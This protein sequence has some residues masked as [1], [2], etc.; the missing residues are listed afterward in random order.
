MPPRFWIAALL[1]I[2]LA[3]TFLGCSDESSN[4]PS[5][6]TL[7]N[8]SYDPTR[9]LW[10]DLNAAFGPTYQDGVIK[11]LKFKQSH[12]GSGSQARAVCDGLAADVVTLALE[13]DTEA[14]RKQGLI[15]EGWQDRLPNRSVPYTSIVVFLVRKGNPHQIKDWPDLVKGSIE[16]I[17]P[18]PK[19]SG[20]GRMTFLAAWGSVVLTG[21]TDEQAKTYVKQLYERIV[22]LDAGARGSTATFGVK[23]IGDVLITMESEAYVSMQDAPGEFELVYP[24]ISFLHEPPL[25]VVDQVVDR[26]GTRAAAEAYLKF[27]YTP[28]GQEIIAKHFFRP[29]DA[30]VLEKHKATFPELK[31]FTVKEIAGDWKSAQQRF[32]D[33]DGVFD[34]IYKPSA[35][36]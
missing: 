18:N 9:E 15:N 26:K 24:S 21:G 19:T 7:M 17:S 16:L 28:T 2:V 20:N 23:G 35:D 10:K 6:A 34:A 5:V 8:V 11:K 31:L 4:D 29:I 27:L 1:S 12:A 13:P 32:F 25:A 14:I 3:W 22:V 30:A 36:H 33:D